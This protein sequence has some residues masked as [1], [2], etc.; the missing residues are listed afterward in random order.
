MREKLNIGLI[1]NFNVVNQILAH[2]TGAKIRSDILYWY[3]KILIC[4]LLQRKIFQLF[5]ILVGMYLGKF[6]DGCV[7]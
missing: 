1:L 3:M 2:L 7:L 5:G 4:Q 6:N